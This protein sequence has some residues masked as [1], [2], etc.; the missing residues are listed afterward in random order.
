MTLRMRH[1]LIALVLVVGIAGSSSVQAQDSSFTVPPSAE[2]HQA[3]GPVTAFRPS[4]TDLADI[5]RVE[6]YLNEIKTVESK[7]L[8]TAS[9]GHEAHGTFYMMRPGRMRLEYDPPIKDEVVADGSF[10]FFWD[11]ELKQQSSTPLGGSLADFIL[12]ENLKMAGD[13]TV[14]GVIRGPGL[15]EISLVETAETGKGELTLVFDDRPL[16]LRKWRVID[17]QRVMTTVALLNPKLG[18]PLKRDLF[19]FHDHSIEPSR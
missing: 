6:K 10:L 12:R 7:F 19:F 18:V 15:L 2:R 17:A 14:T 3:Q 11:D 9:N 16:R 5:A 4:P 8:H 1:G 13:I